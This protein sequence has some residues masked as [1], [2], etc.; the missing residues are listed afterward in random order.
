MVP[1]YYKTHEHFKFNGKHY[2][3]QTLKTL[4]ETFLKGDVLYK[5]DIGTFLLNWLDKKETITLKTSGS[6][7]K[8]K[9]ITISKQRM[10]NSAIATRD[11][12]NLKPG[13]KALLCLPTHY[14]AGKMMLVRALIIGLEIDSIEPKSKLIID[15][16]KTYDFAAMVP[17]Q[18]QSNLY[19]VDNIKTLIVGGAKVS[20]ALTKTLQDLKTT[21]FETYGMTETVSHIALKQLNNFEAQQASGVFKTL[22]EVTISQNENNCLE[23]EAPLLSSEKVITNDVVKLHTKQTFEWLGRFDN[24]IN[25]GGIKVFP[26]QI[27]NALQSKI[28]NRFFIASEEDKTLGNRIILVVEG[29]KDSI[30]SS[31]FNDL[32]PYKKPKYIYYLDAFA[33]TASGKIQRIKTLQ[34]LKK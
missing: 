31:V 15:K 2:N 32:E 23:I 8:P 3:A 33:E 18:L 14:I 5:K 1:E 24:V 17:L 6:T 26:E 20:T 21:V 30:I 13:D 16:S 12:F 27:E 7:G 11:F 28:S 34:L 4:S 19:S 29:Q 9:T 10:I 22:P 25:S